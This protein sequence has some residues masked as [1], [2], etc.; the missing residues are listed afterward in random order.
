MTATGP[1]ESSHL[2]SV[3]IFSPLAAAAVAALIRNER[4]L[5][6]WTLAFTSAVALFSL[7]L[8]WRFDT[9]TSH[10]QFT[11]LA[12]WIPW[13]RID[14]AVGID[15]ISL[16][17]VLLT[18]LIMPLCVMASWRYIQ[19][20]V[21]EFMICLLIMETAMVGV[22]CA[23]DFVLFFIFWEAML[24]PMALLIGVWGGPRKI[25]AAL[26]FFVYTMAGS[27][28]LLVAI[29]A[30]RLKVGS[31]SIPDM[32]GH[33]YSPTFQCW[34]FLAFFISFAIKV[35]MFPFHTWLP[36]A[37]VEAPTAGSVLL[38]SV[39][40]KMGTYGFLRFSLPITPLA[41]QI[42][43]PY[44][45]WLSVA[46]ILY[47]GL[48]AL[49]Q[50]D[51]KKLVAYSSVAH[52]GFATLGIFALNKLGIEGAV[53]VMINHGV[54]TGALFIVVGIIYERLH[55]RD[56][57][58]AAGIGKVM[59]IFALFA[60]VFALSSLAF[61]G[62]NS[63]IGEFLVM[64]GG[65]KLAVENPAFIGA[66]ICVVPGVVLAAAYMLRML[67]KVAYGG[68]SNP[69]HSHLKDLGLREILTLAPLL[70]FVFW[71]GLH[72]EP[73]TRVL[74]TSV[75]HLLD[76]AHQVHPITTYAVAP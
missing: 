60:G 43:T 9:E 52:M 44:V 74:D 41:T 18:T 22:F 8:Y 66:M 11:E 39:L 49:A 10:F 6:L 14:Y 25:Y 69:D 24:I 54:T 45:L 40:L 70:V 21:K 50:T 4:L 15:G 65:F 47:G 46:A 53:L 55:T 72:P 19:T 56:L 27:V 33:N 17:L 64:S 38:A 71:I 48:T 12:H 75:K 1:N 32:M 26:K 3:L 59:P 62:T 30:L 58:E 57:S 63:F 42:F 20:R 37:H 67:Q 2:L 5:R 29:I 7:Q 68:T 16:L 35:P 51:L 13:L 61:P 36:A 34:I 31:F 76:Q 28:M 73:F 23:L